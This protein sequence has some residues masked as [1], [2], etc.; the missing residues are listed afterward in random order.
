MFLQTGAHHK[1][2]TQKS[3]VKTIGIAHY[4]AENQKHSQ[5]NNK[6]SSLQSIEPKTQSKQ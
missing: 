1:T 6:Y 2:K 4:K 3:R 5:N